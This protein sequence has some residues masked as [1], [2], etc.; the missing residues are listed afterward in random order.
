MHSIV[1][2]MDFLNTH[3]NYQATRL[4]RPLMKEQDIVIIIIN[5]PNPA[6][7]LAGFGRVASIAGLSQPNQDG[8]TVLS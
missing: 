6:K 7:G 2:R 4:H 5:I 8:W 1:T 3:Y